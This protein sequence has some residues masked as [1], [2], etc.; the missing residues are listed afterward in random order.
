VDGCRDHQVL[1]VLL[2][3]SADVHADDLRGGRRSPRFDRLAFAERL[4]VRP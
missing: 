4:L 2:V 1:A 3:A